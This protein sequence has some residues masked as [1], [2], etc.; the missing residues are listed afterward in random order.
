MID[1]IRIIGK[2]SPGTSAEATDIELRLI[3]INMHEPKLK[4]QLAVNNIGGADD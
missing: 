4:R 2:R 1:L 3:W